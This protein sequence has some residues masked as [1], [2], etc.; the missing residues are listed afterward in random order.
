[1]CYPHKFQTQVARSEFTVARSP[2]IVPLIKRL[3]VQGLWRLLGSAHEHLT[4][5]TIRHHGTR[6]LANFSEQRPENCI[7]SEIDHSDREPYTA[8]SLTR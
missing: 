1:M 6:A 7:V 4:T 8:P 2:L 3:C 5:P